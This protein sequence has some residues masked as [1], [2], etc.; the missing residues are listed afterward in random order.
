[1]MT[2]TNYKK[3]YEESIFEKFN[4]QKEYDDYKLLIYIKMI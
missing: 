3:L 1:M 2:E 4:L